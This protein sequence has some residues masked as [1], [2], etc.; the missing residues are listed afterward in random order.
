MTLTLFG[1]RVEVPMAST[2]VSTHIHW[3]LTICPTPSAVALTHVLVGRG[4][5]LARP[6]VAAEELV[7]VLQAAGGGAAGLQQTVQGAHGVGVHVSEAIEAVAVALGVRRGVGDVALA[8]VVEPFAFRV[9]QCGFDGGDVRVHAVAVG[10]TS[11]D[12]P[13]I[14]DAFVF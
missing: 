14:A 3:L 8:L 7:A 13:G 5:L 6:M 12:L 9:A 2:G 4:V 10:I 1:D 11:K